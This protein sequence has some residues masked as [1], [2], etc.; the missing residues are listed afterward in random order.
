LEIQRGEI[1][2]LLG[3]NGS[4]KSTLIKILSGFHMP[5]E[6]AICLVR[7]EQLEF[8]SP[9]KSARLGLRF[10]HQDLGLIATSSVLDNLAFT[11]GYQ[12][13]F[14]T[15]RGKLELARARTALEMI[16]LHLDPR[17]MVASL[18]PAQRTGLAV[19]RAVYQDQG[20]AAVLVLD[21]PTATLPSEEVE[22][23]HA[24]IRTTAEHGLGV[25]YVS[26][27][28]D[29]VFRLADTVSVL[30]DG[31]LVESCNIDAIDHA[32]LVH[33]LVGSELEAVTKER[34]SLTPSRQRTSTF[35]I[36]DLHS[37]F[38]HGVS[39]EAKSGE[40]VG[41]YGLTG[42]GRESILGAVFGAVP[43]KSGDVQIDERSTPAFSPVQSIA[44]GIGYVP[45][46][47]K[48]NG[49]VM[50]LDATENLTLVDVRP[51]R[52]KGFLRGKRERTEAKAWFERL[53]VSPRDGVAQPLAS[54]SGGNQ[55]K[56]VLGKWLRMDPRVLLLDEPTQGVD[57]GAKAQLHRLIMEAAN[58][59]AIVLISST[60]LEELTTICGRVVVLRN[61]TISADLTGNDVNDA[62]INRELLTT[63]PRQSGATN[64]ETSFS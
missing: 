40:I 64:V 47:R 21:E 58:D 12:T 51:F 41:I 57:V 33:R 3:Q 49:G 37:E 11:S 63:K 45:P 7:G 27:H 4:G 14:G 56:L 9:A 5:D 1:R 34:V 24:M 62:R 48:V 16:G 59:G 17:Q 52:K 32:T 25:I 22:H 54:F 28:I 8:G 6:G 2:A 39:L 29:E 53:Q 44:A 38:I 15:I 50:Q 13:R 19:A 55:Q 31:N 46:D 60:D 23:L 10:V 43:R 61:G 42:S 30:R 18:T 35:R 20:S 26:H 36:S